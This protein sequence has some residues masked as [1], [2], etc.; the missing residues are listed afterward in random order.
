MR[1]DRPRYVSSLRCLENPS[2][3]VKAAWRALGEIPSIPE[4]GP[5]PKRAAVQLLQPG[6]TFS[7]DAGSPFAVSVIMAECLNH[8]GGPDE[9]PVLENATDSATNAELLCLVR[10]RHG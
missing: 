8:V 5:S 2:K 10:V 9:D 4:K 7:D 6:N 3:K 1:S